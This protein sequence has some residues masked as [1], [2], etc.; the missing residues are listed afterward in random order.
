MMVPIAALGGAELV[1]L[2]RRWRPLA[3]VVVVIGVVSS[4]LVAVPAVAADA[5]WS[6][7]DGAVLAMVN[8]QTESAPPAL[9]LIQSDQEYVMHPISG[10]AN[11]WDGAGSLLYG[12]WSGTTQDIT[13]VA[14]QPGRQT[15]VL[16]LFGP[17]APHPAHLAATLRPIRVKTGAVVSV[18][19]SE[20][21]PTKGQGLT[22][23][24]ASST[25]TTRSALS[26]AAAGGGG[27]WDV[28]VAADGTIACSTAGGL[29]VQTATAISPGWSVG[30]AGPAW[31]GSLRLRSP[32]GL[33]LTLPLRLSGGAVTIL[34]VGP[35]VGGVGSPPVGL[36]TAE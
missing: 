17:F 13:V 29:P 24:A 33:S 30:P 26:C 23:E 7:Q 8:R 10:L 14:T 32:R 20:S 15:Y 25:G 3:A 22:V 4:V 35:A 31:D 5:R 6:R 16:T 1:A 11:R 21:S 9:V 18:H 36:L 19:V 27:G 34:A 2:Y 12:L 28:S